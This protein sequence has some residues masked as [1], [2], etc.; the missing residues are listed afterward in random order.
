MKQRQHK[1]QTAPSLAPRRRSKEGMVGTA[2]R[3][4]RSCM[5]KQ[6]QPKG[7]GGPSGP[8]RRRSNERMGRQGSFP[9]R[10]QQ[11]K[12]GTAARQGRIM[13]EKQRPDH[14][15]PWLLRRRGGF[16]GYRKSPFEGG[17]VRVVVG[18][19]EPLLF[20][21]CGGGSNI[22]FAYARPSENEKT[23]WEAL[24]EVTF[25]FQCFKLLKVMTT[26][27]TSCFWHIFGFAGG[28][29]VRREGHH[30]KSIKMFAAEAGKCHAKKKEKDEAY[31]H[32]FAALPLLPLFAAPTLR[33]P[34][35][36]LRKMPVLCISCSGP[37]GPPWPSCGPL[38]ISGAALT[39]RRP[40]PEFWLCCVSKAALT[41]R[42]ASS[43]C[44][45]AQ[46][47]GLNDP[48]ALL[49]YCGISGA[50]LTG[51][52]GFPSFSQMSPSRTRNPTC[53]S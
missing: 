1:G 10:A 5:I 3:Q 28:G 52:P 39:G 7:N 41:G 17:K 36:I 24:G 9:C 16:Q 38:F 22:A 4:G 42:R 23:G 15:G 29:G 45:V 8:R 34:V 27:V 18:D 48:R 20:G 13:D 33:G 31:T 37:D 2:A 30:G 53:E 14:D 6:R 49:M 50:R 11:R 43:T 44:M 46:R 35:S 12:V 40:S 26:R 25:G 51:R 19:Y 47:L 32:T 21:G